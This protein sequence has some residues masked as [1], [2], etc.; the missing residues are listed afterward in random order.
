MFVFL[1]IRRALSSP[2]FP[3][4]TLFR[5]IVIDVCSGYVY[6]VL[7]DFGADKIPIVFLNTND[8]V[9]DAGTRSNIEDCRFTAR[10]DNSIIAFKIGRAS[11]RERVYYSYN[12]VAI[13]K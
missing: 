6:G 8:G 1:L 10:R 3:Y 13:I 7:I 4:T 11:C 12:S 2:L 5:S 9:N